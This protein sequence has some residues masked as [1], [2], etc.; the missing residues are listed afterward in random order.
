MVRP[1]GPFLTPPSGKL[2]EPESQAGAPAQQLR[3]SK[4][5]A[6]PA[7]EVMRITDEIARRRAEGRDVVSLCAG[8]P[9]ARPA[10]GTLKPAGY[11]GPLGTTPLR[12]AIAGHYL[13]WYGVEI[14]P[15]RIAVTTGSSGAFQLVF[16]A[17]FDPGD[18][19]ALASPGYPAYR[20]ILAALGVQVIEIQT[21]IETRY[22]PTPEMLDAAALEHGPLAG[23]IVASPANPTGTM[24]GR[25]E[26]AALVNWCR[27]RGTRFISDEIY[28]GITFAGLGGAGENGP[29]RGYRSYGVEAKADV[30]AVAGADLTLEGYLVRYE[31]SGGGYDFSGGGVDTAWKVTPAST[32]KAGFFTGGG[33]LNSDRVS[34]GVNYAAGGGFDIGLEAGHIFKPGSDDNTVGLNLSYKFG[35]GSTFGT[36][37]FPTFI[38]AN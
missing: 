9:S 18:R 4:R 8:E 10:P 30:G 5:S 38:P 36:R 31:K 37:N 32:L 19:V 11:T 25:A 35:Q 14:D 23:V 22:Q 17:A 34:V 29:T 16:L 33:D 7:F 13:D 2:P 6:I 27:A 12:Q 1:G 3:A 28:H 24:L 15:K 20:N 26:L 21:G